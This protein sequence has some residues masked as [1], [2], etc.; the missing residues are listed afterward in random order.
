MNNITI[1]YDLDSLSS[2]ASDYYNSFVSP[3]ICLFGLTTS[4]LSLVVLL[5]INLKEKIFVFMLANTIADFLFLFIEMF[6]FLIRCGSLCSI[7][8]DYIIKCYELYIYLILGYILVVFIAINDLALSL[9]RLVIL[10]KANRQLRNEIERELNNASGGNIDTISKSSSSSLS[11]RSSS[12]SLTDSWLQHMFHQAQQF[13]LGCSKRPNCFRLK[14]ALHFALASLIVVPLFL[15]KE[16]R[17]VGLWDFDDSLEPKELYKLETIELG[18]NLKIVFSFISLLKG[19]IL[20]GMLLA[21]NILVAIWFRQNI[22]L[23]LQ[24]IKLEEKR[25]STNPATITKQRQLSQ[26]RRITLMTLVVCLIYLIGNSM[27]S[28]APLLVLLR[29]DWDMLNKNDQY[30]IISNTLFF[31]SHGLFFF[32]YYAFNR[33]FKEKFHSLFIGQRQQSLLRKF[34]SSMTML[35][36]TPFRF[37]K[38]NKNVRFNSQPFIINT[39]TLNSLSMSKIWSSQMSSHHSMTQQPASSPASAPASDSSSFI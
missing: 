23:R 16:I 5:N 31:L 24:L 30:L 26:S 18:A 14:F 32:V 28:I 37:K 19:P 25:E 8:Y 35:S 22:S 13:L 15:A 27:D 38:S 29:Q 33:E 39:L 4:M 11:S 9:E 21:V 1:Y 6:I 7:S 36:S 17:L 12:D 34:K 10:A 2:K 20:F 3:L